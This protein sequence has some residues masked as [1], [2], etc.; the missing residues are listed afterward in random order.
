M[1][2]DEPRRTAVFQPDFFEV[3]SLA[4]AKVRTVTPEFGMSSEERWA[5]ETPYLVDDIG[6]YL[7]ITPESWLVDYGCGTGRVSKGLIEKYGCR[8]AG[9]DASRAMR[10]FAPEYVLSERFV[11]WSPEVLDQM[12]ARGFRAD[13][14]IC[15]WVLQHAFDPVDLIQRIARV[16]KPGGQL[17]S[18]NGKWRC[19][20]TDRGFVDDG[21]DMRAALAGALAEE[22]VAAL[23]VSVAPAQLAEN[24]LI[25]VLR[26]R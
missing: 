18:L 1:A 25:Q 6:R 14:C 11:T 2:S 23:P 8:V 9:I 16:L 15:L 22:H 21:F 19:V 26:K 5:K 20:P 17:Y 7:P 10:L 4:I 13:F 3:P 24:T 12:I